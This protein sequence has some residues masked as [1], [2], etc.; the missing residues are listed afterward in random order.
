MKTF[1]IN[2]DKSIKNFEYQKPFL[3]NLGL[4]VERFNGIN[5]LNNDHLDYKNYI[6]ELALTFSPKGVIG[7]GL[8]HILLCEKI[9]NLNLDIALIMEDDAF[10][11]FEKKEFNSIL[12][13]TI[14]E[15][16][17]LDKDWDIIQLHSD[18]LFPTHDTYFTHTFCGSTA[19]YLLS[20]KGAIKMSNEKACWHIDVQTSSN[21]KFKKYRS[22]Y[23]LFWTQ[24]NYSLNRNFSQNFLINIKS[25][26]LSYIIPLRGEKTWQDFLNFKVL[27]LP[28]YKELTAD[29]I[30][31]LIIGY[32]LYK[33]ITFQIKRR[34]NYQLTLK[35]F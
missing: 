5:A 23:N 7:C 31:N 22:K 11:L 29:E 27:N 4:Q 1:V 16:S 26:I 8:S 9:K 21:H 6:N 2:L 25:Q 33:F 28:S 14:N 20:R 15:I 24:E 12:K 35:I 10:P 30:I 32:F 17:I 3:E 18:A 19:A 34:I 13:K